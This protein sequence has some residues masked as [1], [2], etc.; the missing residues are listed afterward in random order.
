MSR[1]HLL[2]LMEAQPAL[3]MYRICS[4]SA[5]ALGSVHPL[6]PFLMSLPSATSAGTLGSICAAS[7]RWSFQREPDACHRRLHAEVA[8]EFSPDQATPGRLYS[9]H[10]L[11]WAVRSGGPGVDIPNHAA[12]G[13]LFTATHQGGR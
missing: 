11:G 2:A 10:P 1:A 4:R 7:I 5:G 8:S 13:R 12:H 9:R 3:S 6:L